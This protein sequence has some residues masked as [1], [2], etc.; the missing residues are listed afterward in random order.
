ME[1]EF[2]NAVRDLVALPEVQQLRRYTHHRHT[3]RYIH[4]MRVARLSFR[5]AKRL[6]LDA[7]AAARG[8]VLHDLF[9]HDRSCRPENY[10]GP[11]VLRHPEEAAENAKRLIALSPKEENII[12][13]HMWPMSRHAPHSP[14]AVLVN[15]ADD[16]VAVDDLRQKRT[17]D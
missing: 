9:F 5:V 17:K 4:T 2:D 10:R 1:I 14:E 15:L 16:L 12:L 8:A 13:S 11:V 6:G 7:R 3:N